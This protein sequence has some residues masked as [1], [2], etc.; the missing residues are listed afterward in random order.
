MADIHDTLI[1]AAVWPADLVT[2]GIV[3]AA[4]QVYDG[5]RIQGVQDSTV[6]V[7]LEQEA[8][9]HRGT[10]LP[11]PEGEAHEHCYQ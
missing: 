11:Y 1:G 10:V 7:W 5:R 2:A 3:S 8:N 6:E 9:L 4:S